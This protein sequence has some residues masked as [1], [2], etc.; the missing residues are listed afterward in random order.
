MAD[1]VKLFLSY[2]FFW[3]AFGVVARII[4]LAYQFEHTAATGVGDVVLAI[5][6]GARLDLTV[7]GYLTIIP[8]VFMVLTAHFKPSVLKWLIVP[9]SMLLL[10]ATCFIVVLDMEL[11]HHWSFRLDATP[12]LYIGKEA[13]GSGDLWTTVV[14]VVFWLVFFGLSAIAFQKIVAGQIDRLSRG[15]WK[16]ALTILLLTGLLIAPIRGTVGVA[17]IN[18]GTVYFHDN[19]MFANHA[20]INVLYNFGYAIRKINRLR[21]PENYVDAETTKKL[22]DELIVQDLASPQWID[23]PMPNIMI[24]MLE[25]YTFRFVEPLGGL[26]G[27]TPNINR[28][29]DEGV[30]FSRF[31]SSGDRTDMGIISVLNGYPRQPLGSVIK[32]PKK[33][34]S[35]PYINKTLKKKDY[36]TEFT[37][38]YNID[39]ANFKSFLANAQFDHVTHSANFPAEHNTSKWGVHDHFVFDRY[40][41][42]ANAAKE[43]FFKIMMT[44]SSHEPFTVP[45]ETKIEGDDEVSMFLNSAYYTDKCLG[46]FIAKAKDTDWWENTWIIV[47]ADHGHFMPDNDG[48]ANPNRF[49]IPMLWLGGAL[50]VQDTVVSTYG[51]H[52]DI[53]NTIFGQLGFQDGDFMFSSNMLSKNFKPF[54]VFIYN[55]GVG[56]L[57]ESVKVVYD[58]VGKQFVLKN[59]VDDAADENRGRAYL[60][61]LYKDFNRR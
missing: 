33:T 38:G 14:L 53:A 12:L 49:K 45:M 18:T 60:Q 36:Y 55:N 26:P 29:A 25:S 37:Y 43:P 32:F 52:T 35:L 10:L 61:M 42:E 2:F 54:S 24:I 47:T 30:L 40:F 16:T 39:Y 3:M 27:I 57:S 58:N 4:F 1:R 46:D 21:Y 50:A 51:T 28:L 6:H 20:A 23:S 56:Y 59:G 19:D 48:I 15:N 13:A 44:Q 7:A 34:A 9:Y 41:E 8:G 11:Y 22:F 17:P 31:Y 5:F